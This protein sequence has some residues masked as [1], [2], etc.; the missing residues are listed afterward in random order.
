MNLKDIA[1]FRLTSQQIINSELKSSAKIA[2]WMGAMQ[3]QDFN[4]AKWAIALRL[5]NVFQKDIE[6]AINSGEIIRTHVL[7]PTW[8]FVSSND[9]YWMLDLTAPKI[10][11]SMKGRLKQLELTESVLKKVIKPFRKF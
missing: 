5:E 2:G 7:R 6:A 9:I 1:N 4:M 3:S 8:H 10:K 11:A